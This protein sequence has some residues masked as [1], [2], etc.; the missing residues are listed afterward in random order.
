MIFGKF[1]ERGA[2]RAEAKAAVEQP[3]TRPAEARKPVMADRPT[4]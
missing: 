2:A 4:E 3:G 1:D